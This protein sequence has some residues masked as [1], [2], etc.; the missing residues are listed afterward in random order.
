MPFSTAQR[1]GRACK[2][3]HEGQHLG[4]GAVVAG[5]KEGLVLVALDDVLGRQIV[6]GSVPEIGTLGYI[7]VENGNVD[8]EPCF[9]IVAVRI[10]GRPIVKDNS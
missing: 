10:Y 9:S 6:G 5:L 2:T 3:P 8:R 4:S 1:V 7:P